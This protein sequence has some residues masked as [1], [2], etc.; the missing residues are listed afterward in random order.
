[1]PKLGIQKKE[2]ASVTITIAHNGGE[3]STSVHYPVVSFHEVERVNDDYIFD[4]LLDGPAQMIHRFE[5]LKD[6]NGVE[7][8]VFDHEEIPTILEALYPAFTKEQLYNIA[9]EYLNS[10]RVV[11]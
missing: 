4:G 10:L 6:E 11:T 1:M 8:R 5:I 3:P 2:Y 9:S 7:A